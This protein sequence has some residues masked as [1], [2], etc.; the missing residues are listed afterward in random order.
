MMDAKTADRA[1]DVFVTD[2]ESAGNVEQ[3]AAWLAARS[4]VTVITGAGVSTQSGIPD[5]RDGDGNWK[6]SPPVQYADFVH[7]A[8]TRRR[9]W[10]RSFTGWPMFAAARPNA[11][12]RALAQLEARGKVAAL[13][14]QNVDGLHQRAG[15][16]SVIDLHGRLDVVRCLDCNHRSGRDAFQQR[17]RTA[18]PEWAASPARIAPDGDADVEGR[19]FAAFNVPA[20]EVCG[21]LLK[22]DVVFY[23]ESVPRAVTDSA[24]AAVE[25]A[26]G[27][28]V[29]GSSLMVWSS[30]RLIRAAATRGVPVVAVNRGR[31]R[32]DDL[33]SF[34]LDGECGAVLGAVVGNV[35]TVG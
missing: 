22:P 17:L 27:V 25:A 23:G 10:A 34:K 15:S 16:R 28:L 20:C 3:L 18:N 24:F 29:V 11:A 33:F 19:D 6:R 2:L 1:D 4:R 7:G 5:Y 8:A 12:H 13:V 35:S 14:T 21:G 30:F 26:D 32:A 31:T 9:Y